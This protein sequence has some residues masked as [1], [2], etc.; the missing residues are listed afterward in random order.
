MYHCVQHYHHPD[1]DRSNP[2]WWYRGTA[3]FFDGLLWP[4]TP[5]MWADRRWGPNWSVYPE[6]YDRPN[7]DV[8]YHHDG[9]G[10]LFWHAAH[11]NAGWQPWEVTRWIKSRSSADGGWGPPDPELK[12]VFHSFG[13]ALTRGAIRY[14]ETSPVNTSAVGWDKET[15]LA[16]R[17]TPV[18][19]YE[20]D[21]WFRSFQVRPWDVKTIEIVLEDI[22]TGNDTFHGWSVSVEPDRFDLAHPLDDSFAA[23]DCEYAFREVGKDNWSLNQRR[24][25]DPP[26][27]GVQWRGTGPG[28]FE[29][30][31]TCTGRRGKTVPFQ[32]KLSRWY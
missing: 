2:P 25:G 29:F 24:F 6:L 16:R 8:F 13:R 27:S 1:I 14:S 18:A 22:G 15:R 5:D 31:F 12:P 10:A 7:A 11:L 4:A 30:L 32:L 3:R 17:P 23:D 9:S 28:R 19:L 21:G 26:D 20:D